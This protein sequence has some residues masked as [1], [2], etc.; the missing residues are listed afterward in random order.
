MILSLTR[1]SATIRNKKNSINF[2]TQ[3]PKLGPDKKTGLV[4]RGFRNYTVSSKHRL[5][6][7]L[8][9]KLL[10][11]LSKRLLLTNNKSKNRMVRELEKMSRLMSMASP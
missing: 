11:R 1:T 7:I 3:L 10:K 4:L 8:L 5:L 2:L 6:M 9:S